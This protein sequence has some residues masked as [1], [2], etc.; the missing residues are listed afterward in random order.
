MGAQIA[1]PRFL[2]ISLATKPIRRTLISRCSLEKESSLERFKRTMSP[3]SKVTGR[4]PIS[5]ILAYSTR[6]IVDF[7]DPDSPVNTIN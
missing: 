6:A 1:T 4:F 2:V 7:P 5:S 3:S